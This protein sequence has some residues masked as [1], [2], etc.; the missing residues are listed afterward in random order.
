MCS[1]HDDT[2]GKLTK[3]LTKNSE[4]RT[5]S[6]LGLLDE[7]GGDCGKLH[8]TLEAIGR[9]FPA[10]MK[11]TLG[12]AIASEAALCM[13]TCPFNA[14]SRRSAARA[15]ERSKASREAPFSCNPPHQSITQIRCVFIHGAGVS[16]G[17]PCPTMPTLPRMSLCVL[18][19]N[20]F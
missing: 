11:K 13:C 19:M 5:S 16:R 14:K 8:A 3:K 12:K 20:L 2:V 17:C 10:F 4:A 1:D 6:C 7:K 9:D 15:R 18:S